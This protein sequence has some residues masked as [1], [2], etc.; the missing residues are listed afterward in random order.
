MRVELCSMWD[1]GCGMWVG[2]LSQG[3]LSKM[4]SSD[5]KFA[6]Q[7][8]PESSRPVVGNGCSSGVGT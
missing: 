2:D 7:R 3:E 5:A 6:A 8:K 1:V 4:I